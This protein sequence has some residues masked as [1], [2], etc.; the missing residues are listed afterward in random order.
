DRV[1]ELSL[2]PVRQ[3]EARR[4]PPDL[5]SQAARVRSVTRLCFRRPFDCPAP[6][7]A[8][9]GWATDPEGRTREHSPSGRGDGAGARVVC[10][11]WNGSEERSVGEAENR[12]NKGTVE[13]VIPHFTG[14]LGYQSAAVAGSTMKPPALQTLTRHMVGA[15]RIVR[16]KRANPKCL[17]KMILNV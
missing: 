15:D 6:S 10:R 4:Q 16:A 7:G 17:C 12:H 11:S 8:R 13:V 5:R 2:Q 1:C 14:G 3:S 9:R